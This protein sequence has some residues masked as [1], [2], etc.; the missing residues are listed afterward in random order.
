[1][2]C[3]M[4]LVALVVGYFTADFCLPAMPGAF[5]FDPA[6]SVDG[7]RAR[8]ANVVVAPSVVTDAFIPRL[9]TPVL[10]RLAQT[11]TMTPHRAPVVNR[12]PRATLDPIPSAEDPH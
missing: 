7:S 2:I 5:V 10:T 6:D 3:R 8:T 4:L 11:E 1:M 9:R 12:L